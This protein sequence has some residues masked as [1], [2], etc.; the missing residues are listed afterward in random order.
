LSSLTPKNLD[1]MRS[2][3]LRARRLAESI[4]DKQTIANLRSYADQLESEVK[5]IEAEPP[6]LPPQAI[7]PAA[8][9]EPVTGPAVIAALEPDPNTPKD[10]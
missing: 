9:N 4:M 7:P 3:I 1:E 6:S 10:P 2:L 8:G 5:R